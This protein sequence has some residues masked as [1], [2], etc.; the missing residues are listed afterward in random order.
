MVL[1][2]PQGVFAF[3]ENIS[4]PATPTEFIQSELRETNLLVGLLGDEK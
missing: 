2:A 4:A 3:T 1:W